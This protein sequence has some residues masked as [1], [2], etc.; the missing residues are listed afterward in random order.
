MRG[1]A[2]KKALII[3]W[4]K[5]YFANYIKDG[6]RAMLHELDKRGGMQA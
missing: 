4:V 6:A 1:F 2:L 5:E 3:K